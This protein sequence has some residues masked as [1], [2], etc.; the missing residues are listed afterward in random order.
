MS[1][2]KQMSLGEIINRLSSAIEDDELFCKEELEMVH[3]YCEQ[4][5]FM[6]SAADL[7]AI[8]RAG[9]IDSFENWKEEHSLYGL[10]FEQAKKRK[11][12]FFTFNELP[13]L[14]DDLRHGYMSATCENGEPY[15]GAA[16]LEIGHVDV[17]LNI[18]TYEQTGIITGFSEDKRPILG[19]F[20]CIK[21]GER[22]DDWVSDNYIDND[23]HINWHAD[24]WQEVLE[25]DMFL[26]LNE[27]VIKHHLSY[28]EPNI[29]PYIQS[30]PIVPD[31]RTEKDSYESMVLEYLE[32]FDSDDH[33][34]NRDGN[35]FLIAN[36][37]TFTSYKLEVI[38][39][40]LKVLQEAKVLQDCIENAKSAY[41]VD[42]EI[43]NK[44]Q[45][46][47]KKW[48]KKNDISINDDKILKEIHEEAKRACEGLDEYCET[49]EDSYVCREHILRI[50]DIIENLTKGSEKKGE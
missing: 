14:I 40:R 48:Y 47:E 23:I 24:D 18:T 4:K 50:L 36:Y 31:M 1:T 28:D 16:V 34:V 3:N 33:I 46:F 22:D 2:T 13:S 32:L 45:D 9:L 42:P 12:Y 27:Y 20:V 7:S 25:K 17:E 21:Q 11:D 8:R 30:R 37:R 10:T 44:I 29:R 49:L 41:D 15:R 39:G 35:N 43:M 5:N 26:A 19:Y 38:D 6:M